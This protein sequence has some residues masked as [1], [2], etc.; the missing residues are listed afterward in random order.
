[1]MLRST[2]ESRA[3]SEAATEKRSKRFC[4]APP[5]RKGWSKGKPALD[6]LL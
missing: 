1:M 6:T 5:R 4:P 3:T 2:E